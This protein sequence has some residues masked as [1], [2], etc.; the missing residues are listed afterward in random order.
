M[1]RSHSSSHERVMSLIIAQLYE[2]VIKSS[3]DQ[4]T[5]PPLVNTTWKTAPEGNKHSMYNIHEAK[6][7]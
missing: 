3:I 1:Q 2:T 5:P 4:P 7:L 6:P